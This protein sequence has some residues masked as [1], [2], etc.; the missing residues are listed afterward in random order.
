MGARDFRL[1]TEA[2]IKSA[3][4]HLLTVLDAWVGEWLGSA[5]RRDLHVSCK[6]VECE[7]LEAENEKAQWFC[8]VGA[9]G[10]VW[11]SSQ[12][13]QAVGCLLFG[14]SSLSSDRTAFRVCEHALGSLL[15][16]IA[17]CPNDAATPLLSAHAPPTHLT[18][19]GR[20]GLVFTIEAPNSVLT[21]LVERKPLAAQLRTSHEGREPLGSL[22]EG[23][24]LQKVTIGAWLGEA[25]IELG[26]LKSL[27]VGDVLQLDRL[28]SQG[29]DIRVGDERLQCEG[30]LCV[31][32]GQVAIEVVRC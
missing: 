4:A 23:I 12:Q 15:C 16:Q 11:A 5:Q 32:D 29:A 30:N 14:Q 10:S 7:F 27:E 3:H 24:N 17:C 6:I 19:A 20:W 26:V 8:C 31:L 25:E 9:E 18:T 2:D 22:R 1:C 28:L 21:L 13:T